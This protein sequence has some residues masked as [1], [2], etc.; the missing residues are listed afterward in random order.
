VF[1]LIGLVVPAFSTSSMTLLQETVEPE[2]HGRVFG[3]VG[4]VMTL[5]MPV[6][7]AILGP[8]ADIVSVEFL[9]IVTGV[10]TVLIAVLSVLL[11]GGKKAIAAAHASTGSK[12]SQESTS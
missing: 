9:L 6:G 4:I 8:L 5:A 1:F 10:M 2:R 3:F 12:I 7:M 11:P